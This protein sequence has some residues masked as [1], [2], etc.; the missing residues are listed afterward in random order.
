MKR[1]FVGLACHAI[2]GCVTMFAVLLYLDSGI[3]WLSIQHLEVDGNM[4][5][6]PPS[7]YALPEVHAEPSKVS[8]NFF[9]TSMPVMRSTARS[10]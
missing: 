1:F 7:H 6:K 8:G 3:A 5:Y 10:R 2:T 4:I 9:E